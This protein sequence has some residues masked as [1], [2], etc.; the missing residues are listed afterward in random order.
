MAR[1]RSRSSAVC[2]KAVENIEKK[3]L[4][5]GQKKV[6]SSQVGEE[7]MYCLRDMDKVAYVRFA[8]VYREFKDV[9][10]FMDELKSLLKPGAQQN[11]RAGDQ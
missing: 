7:V 3:F 11:S 2:A 4:S 8:S 6:P 9:T 10:E 5:L 1:M